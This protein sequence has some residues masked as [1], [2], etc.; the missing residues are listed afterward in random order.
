[1]D[2]DYTRGTL[3]CCGYLMKNLILFAFALGVSLTH[4]GLTLVAFAEEVA[5]FTV[6]Y[7]TKPRALCVVGLIALFDLGLCLYH[8]QWR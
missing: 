7:A 5:T 1:M 3:L 6:W 2:E 8:K 4:G